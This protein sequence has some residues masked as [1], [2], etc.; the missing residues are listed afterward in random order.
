L[1]LH[2]SR[3]EQLVSAALVGA[4]VAGLQ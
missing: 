4:D 1:R 2:I 3:T